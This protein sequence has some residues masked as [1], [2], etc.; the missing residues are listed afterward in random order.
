M[1][2]I[3][4]LLVL[5]IINFSFPFSNGYADC[6]GCCSGNGGILCKNGVTECVDGT[7]LSDRCRN[8]G[9]SACEDEIIINQTSDALSIVSFN[10]MWLGHYTK[11]EHTALAHML[12]DHDIVV[13]Q[14]L[15]SPPVNGRYPNG[16]VY[17]ADSEAADFFNAMQNLGF[18]YLLSEEDTGT[19]PII[20]NNNSST[21]WWVTFYKPA[22]VKTANDIPSGFLANDRSDNPD[23]ERVPYA[24]PFRTSNNNMDFVLISVHLKPGNG[25]S[26]KARREHELNSIETWIN[27]NNNIEK[28]F[29][30]LGDM[31]I[32]NIAELN[33]VIP[34]GFISLNDECLSTVTSGTGMP[35][36]HV[37]F[38]NT[39]TKEIDTQYD[40]KIINLIETMRPYWAYEEDYPG[41]PYDHNQFKQYYS[42]HNPVVFQM[43]L[44][45]SDD[46]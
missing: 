45:L 33:R 32:Y 18:N 44:P 12:K 23:Y 14:E 39:H 6:R 3:K 15:V 30:I 42:D 8:K 25:T 38:N 7:P 19:G 36:D 4:T 27:R 21:E 16:D 37:M 29:I 34:Q 43:I 2:T 35:Y 17:L 41:D 5:I 10:L 24:F 9:C 20:H 40:L 46:D 28:D 13:I 31:N 11:K 22:T 1:K 26:D